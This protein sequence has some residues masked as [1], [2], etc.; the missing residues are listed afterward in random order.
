[1]ILFTVYSEDDCFDVVAEKSLED[2][3]KVILIKRKDD[4]DTVIGKIDKKQLN[5]IQYIKQK[6]G[7]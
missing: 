5:N 3:N 6:M 1:M 7:V 2:K 4:I